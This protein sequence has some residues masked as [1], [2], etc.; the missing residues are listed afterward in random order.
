[1]ATCKTC[2]GLGNLELASRRWPYVAHETCEDCDG[3]GRICRLCLEP[4]PLDSP[5]GPLCTWCDGGEP[6]GHMPPWY[7]LSAERGH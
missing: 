2:E 4:I 7:E 6:D 5:A 1:M 3:T